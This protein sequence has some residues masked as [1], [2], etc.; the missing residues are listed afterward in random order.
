[1]A[2]EIEKVIKSSSNGLEGRES[3]KL[4][5]YQRLYNET[6]RN[7]LDVYKVKPWEVTIGTELVVRPYEELKEID[8]ED[9]LTLGINP[10]MYE[11]IAG[12]TLVVDKDIMKSIEGNIPPIKTFERKKQKEGYDLWWVSL[13]MYQ[14]KEGTITYSDKDGEEKPKIPT[15]SIATKEKDPEIIKEM[16]S[17][18]DYKRFQKLLSISASLDGRKCVAKKEIVDKYLQIWAENKYEFYLLLGRNLRITKEVELDMTR[19]EMR[20][21]INDLGAKFPQYGMMLEMIDTEDFLENRFTSISNSSAFEKHARPFYTKGMKLSKFFTDFCKDN[22]FDIEVSKVMQSKKVKGLI[23]LSI[24]PYDFLTSSI[25]KHNWQSCHRI[26]AGE[27]ATG[28]VSY[29]LDNTTMISYKA[30]EVDYSYEYFGFKFEGNS[31]TFRQLVYFDKDSCNIVFSRQYPNTSKELSAIVREMLESKVEEF[32]N[33]SSD[34]TWNIT[35]DAKEGMFED[36]STLHYSDVNRGAGHYMF[37][38]ITDSKPNIAH[39]T[40]G[41]NAPCVNCGDTHNVR[42]GYR[43]LCTSCERKYD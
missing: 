2:K 28:S 9:L 4:D 11:E 31:K 19:E 27:Y 35:K 29:L 14:L 3:W 26:T 21:L 33:L 15:Y 16:I 34:T 10:T 23:H 5:E 40:V 37:A 38:R 13:P 39:F 42:K 1:M 6:T 22:A 24:D 8:D 43:M 12:I 32:F 30:S 20:V 17:K 41:Y 25:N 36:V 18:V 7:G